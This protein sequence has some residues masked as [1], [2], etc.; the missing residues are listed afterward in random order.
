MADS[1][2]QINPDQHSCKVNICLHY[3]GPVLKV[4]NFF[5]FECCRMSACCLDCVGLISLSV[6]LHHSEKQEIVWLCFVFLTVTQND[7]R[8]CLNNLLDLYLAISWS[9]LNLCGRLQR[10]PT[11]SAHIRPIGN[12]PISPTTNRSLADKRL[13][14]TG[15]LSL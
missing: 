9:V 4:L 12:V 13:G 5:G 14:I 6:Y 3:N 15:V 11:T 2:L 1:A 7:K 10:S 8:Q